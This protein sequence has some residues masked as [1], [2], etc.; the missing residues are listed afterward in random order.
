MKFIDPAYL[1]EQ[2]S[3]EKA[4]AIAKLLEGVP[5]YQA[6]GILKHHAPDVLLIS[7]S[8]CTECITATF[9][10]EHDLWNSQ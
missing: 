4:V 9:E 10:P 1:T 5:L 3:Q 6:L 2:Q 8:V 7:H